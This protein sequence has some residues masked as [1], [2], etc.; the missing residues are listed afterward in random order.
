MSSY[1]HNPLSAAAA[2]AAASTAAHWGSA[3]TALDCN[4]SDYFNSFNIP[5]PSLPYTNGSNVSNSTSPSSYAPQSPNVA[6]NNTE[7]PSPKG[8]PPS[9]LQAT[10]TANNLS[11]NASVAQYV[12]AKVNHC[13]N[14]VSSEQESSP[15][16]DN[17]T[18]NSYGFNNPHHQQVSSHSQHPSSPSAFMKRDISSPTDQ[19]NHQIHNNRLLPNESPS[20]EQSQQPFSAETNAV[21]NMGYYGFEVQPHHHSFDPHHQAMAAMAAATHGQCSADMMYQKSSSF[22][23][24]MKTFGGENCSPFHP[25]FK[26]LELQVTLANFV[27]FQKY[28]FMKPQKGWEEIKSRKKLWKNHQPPENHQKTFFVRRVQTFS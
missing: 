22:Y 26:L 27:G 11:V 13:D 10:S 1:F 16:K 8:A 2:A 15:T 4:K 18:N 19:F 14:Q 5:H 25:A 23:P 6:Q 21:S 17:T 24:W 28:G 20:S 12:G 9:Q 7:S 3:N